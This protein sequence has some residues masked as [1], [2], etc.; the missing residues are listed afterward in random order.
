M[1][2]AFC[3]RRAIESGLRRRRI[4]GTRCRY[5]G[6]IRKRDIPYIL[7]G[8]CY[9]HRMT[10]RQ[11]RVPDLFPSFHPCKVVTSPRF[12]DP[13]P[14]FFGF[15]YHIVLPTRQPDFF[16]GRKHRA[17]VVEILT[18]GT[19]SRSSSSQLRSCCNFQCCPGSHDVKYCR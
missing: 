13:T 4:D 16:S 17:H 6:R 14:L 19:P 10:I 18:I 9:Q 7:F 12:R 15:S 2:E 5:S 8:L 11:P 3:R 1:L